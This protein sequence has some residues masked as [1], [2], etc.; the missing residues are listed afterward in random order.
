MRFLSQPGAGLPVKHLSKRLAKSNL[1]ENRIVTPIF[2]QL[3]GKN[4]IFMA[5]L[6]PYHEALR[7]LFCA[8]GLNPGLSV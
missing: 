3:T 4:R 6:S 2:V 7:G 1:G 5:R 8:G